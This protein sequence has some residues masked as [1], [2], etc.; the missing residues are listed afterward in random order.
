MI[1]AILVAVLSAVTKSFLFGA[2]G[3]FF[4]FFAWN[5]WHEW[6]RARDFLKMAQQESQETQAALLQMLNEQ[7]QRPPLWESASNSV[8][9]ITLAGLW[10][11]ISIIDFIF[12]GFW[13]RTFYAGVWM[14]GAFML[15]KLWL[16]RKHRQSAGGRA[17]SDPWGD[18]T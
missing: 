11:V 13:M 5:K 15:L 6:R 3:L 1:G 17:A 8:A 9:G 14:I 4:C 10:L 18:V 7:S 16:L 2:V 12:A